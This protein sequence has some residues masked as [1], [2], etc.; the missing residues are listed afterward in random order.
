MINRRTFI[1]RIGQAIAGFVAFLAMP[2]KKIPAEQG[3]CGDIITAKW[4]SRLRAFL[5]VEQG[6]CMDFSPDEIETVEKYEGRLI[7]CCKH[8]VWEIFEDN[9][10]VLRRKQISCFSGS[11]AGRIRESDIGIWEKGYYDGARFID[12]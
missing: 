8:S 3:E 10:G 12:C 1:K 9:N 5:P 4:G 2:T 6:K 7:V 11:Q